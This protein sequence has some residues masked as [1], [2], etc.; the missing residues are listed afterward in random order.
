MVYLAP[1]TNNQIM[2]VNDRPDKTNN[3]TYST[4]YIGYSTILFK[5]MIRKTLKHFSK[6][7]IIGTDFVFK[8]SLPPLEYLWNM[9]SSSVRELFIYIGASWD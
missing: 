3:R 1:N 5:T 6:R 4:L 2:Y 7:L 8:N 9:Y